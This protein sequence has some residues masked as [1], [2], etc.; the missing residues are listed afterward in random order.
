M[1]VRKVERVFV[2]KVTGVFVGEVGVFCVID[3]A[4]VDEVSGFVCAVGGVFVGIL[5][6]AVC[7]LV[8]VLSCSCLPINN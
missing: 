8:V 7:F 5:L 3:G 2:G 1:F 6:L 4:F